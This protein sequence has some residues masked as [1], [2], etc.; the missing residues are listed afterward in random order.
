MSNYFEKNGTEGQDEYANLI[1]SLY[2]S[3]I[4][5][6][7]KTVSE[8]VDDIKIHLLKVMK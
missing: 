1:K 6:D 2:E 5:S 7:N 3:S 4:A 8:L